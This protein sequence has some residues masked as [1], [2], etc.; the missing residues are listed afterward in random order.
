MGSELR[1]V[2]AEPTPVVRQHVRPNAITALPDKDVI[3]QKEVVNTATLKH[4]NF[5]SKQIYFLPSFQDFRR[6]QID[7]LMQDMSR[8]IAIYS[9]LF[10]RTVAWDTSPFVY[11]A[12][13]GLVAAPTGAGAKDGGFLAA[14]QASIKTNLTLPVIDNALA[15]LQNDLGAT[16]F[17]GTVNTPKNN[18]L[19]HGKYVLMCHPEDW[20]QLKWDPALKDLKSINMELAVDGF[21]GSLFGMVTTRP[22]K[23]PIRFNI[24][25]DGTVTF[26]DPE[27]YEEATGITRPNTAYTSP[28]QGKYGVAWILGSQAYESIK[29]G[30]PPSEFASGSM[31][32]DKFAALRWNGEVNL[33]KNVL[34]KYADGTLDTN[35]Y[36]DV[37]QLFSRAAFG[38]IGLRPH[39]CLPIVFERKRVSQ[40]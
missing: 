23:Y 31:S 27:T 34:V 37:L 3:E 11:F 15:V 21:K 25:A 38:C 35:K 16:P 32:R 9:D 20:Q 1:G 4:K 28:S 26:P 22:E 30:P 33:T 17:E 13:T 19:L 7:P 2:R 5:E 24:A 10:T 36:G 12:G 14:N 29:V 39:N 8:Q 6:T 40:V 18:E